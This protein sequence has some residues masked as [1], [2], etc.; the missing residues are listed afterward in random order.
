[1]TIIR[2]V[3]NPAAY[4]A[5]WDGESGTTYQLVNPLGTAVGREERSDGWSVDD[6]ERR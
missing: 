5:Q 1:M 4:G 3:S 6:R 2:N